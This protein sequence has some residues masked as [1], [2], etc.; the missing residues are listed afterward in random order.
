MSYKV[1]GNIIISDQR[2]LIG[3]S[4]AGINTAL[5]VGEGANLVTIDGENGTVDAVS[6]TGDGSQLTGIVSNDGDQDISGNLGVTGILTVG[7]G[8][9]VIGGITTLTGGVDLVNSDILNGGIGNFAG[10]NVS[11]VGTFGS[12][13]FTNSEADEVVSGITTD[14]G[15][16]AGADELVTAGGVKGYVDSQLG[17]A[18]QLN[19]AGDTGAQ[20]EVELNGEVLDIK[21]D[22]N[23]I[24]TNVAVGLGQTITVGLST[25]LVFPGSISFNGGDADEV[26]SGITTNLDESAG[27]N[28]LITASGI[29]GYVDSQVGG[30]SNL[31]INDGG[32]GIGT[33]NLGTE[34]LTINGT[35]NEVEVAVSGDPG[36]VTIGLPDS[37]SIASSITA[38]EYFGDGSNLTGIGGDSVDLSGTDQSFNS[39]Q[40][41]GPGFALTVTNDADFNGFLDVAEGVNAVGVV[42]AADF[43]STSDIRKKDNIVEIGDAVAKVKELRGVTF[44]WKDGS[45]HS[46]GVIAQ[47]VEAV[48]PTLVKEGSHKTVNYNGII[49]LLV[50]AVKEQRAEIEELKSKLG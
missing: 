31:T 24:V 29:K 14:L 28:E 18:N 45:G 38:N 37:I 23:E 19:F 21:G 4:T 3:I 41:T 15:E 8:L 12:L 40:L 48:L 11:G 34:Q 39:L 6:Y 36:E 26:V 33:V 50:Q 32:S 16:S 13:T 35:A 46:G 7:Q 47:E 5:Y 27:A 1:L 49:G 30:N 42:T 44:D 25:T 22:V 17:A 10:V 20:G 2:E 43:N 9:S